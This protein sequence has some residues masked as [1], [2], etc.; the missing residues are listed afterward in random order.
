MVADRAGVVPTFFL[1][2]RY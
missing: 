2:V 1:S